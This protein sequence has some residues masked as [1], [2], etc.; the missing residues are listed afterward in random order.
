[1]TWLVLGDFWKGINNQ[2]TSPLG[3]FEIHG[4]GFAD[5]VPGVEIAPTIEV[6]SRDGGATVFQGELP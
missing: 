4:L 6:L 1:M 2:L 3:N 5:S